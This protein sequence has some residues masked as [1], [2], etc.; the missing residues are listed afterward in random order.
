LQV[1]FVFGQ[2]LPVSQ[3]GDLR[4]VSVVQGLML[5]G[6]LLYRFVVSSSDVVHCVA[7]PCV[8]LKCDVVPG[9]SSLCSL[10]LAL[11]GRVFGQCSEVC[12]S[13]HGFMP[14]GLVLG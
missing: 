12:G 9:L 8:S 11:L 1:I 10:S 7:L 13:F 6:G 2:S 4:L 3:V 14:F 5:A